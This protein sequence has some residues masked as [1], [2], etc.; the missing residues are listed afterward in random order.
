M[1]YKKSLYGLCLVIFPLMVCSGMVYSILPLYV[2]GELGASPRHIGL[3]YMVGATAGAILAP[4]LGKLSDKFG[5]RRVLLLSMGGFAAAFALYAVI[6]NYSEAFP[7]YA[8]EGASWAALGATVPAFIADI[9]PAEDR[10]WAMGIYERTWSVG[11]IIG[12]LLGGFLADT[13]GFRITFIAGAALIGI[14]IFRYAIK[15]A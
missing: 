5:R 4:F 11:W 13:I 8:L 14:G 9:V 3:L 10:G 15:P 7:I 2:S 6:K 1:S 12:P